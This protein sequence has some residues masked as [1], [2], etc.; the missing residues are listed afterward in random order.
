MSRKDLAP[1][2]PY[3]WF[4]FPGTRDDHTW[5]S[6][7]TKRSWA[8]VAEG[9][10]LELVIQD[11]YSFCPLKKEHWIVLGRSW[12]CGNCHDGDSCRWAIPTI[13]ASALR[14]GGSRSHRQGTCFLGLAVLTRLP[15]HQSV[16]FT[17][18]VSVQNHPALIWRIRWPWQRTG[19]S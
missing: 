7:A 14:A 5:G 6:R 11:V 8:H 18:A 19:G 16:L 4:P 3:S 10:A 1:V 13:S 17:T 12:D 9:E 2:V 15:S